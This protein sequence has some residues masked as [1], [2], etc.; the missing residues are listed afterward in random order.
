MDRL[1]HLR[2]LSYQRHANLQGTKALFALN[3]LVT[4]FYSTVSLTPASNNARSPIISV[5]G[6][7]GNGGRGRVFRGAF[8]DFWD[9]RT[10]SG[11]RNFPNCLWVVLLVL[12]F[13]Q[14]PRWA[15]AWADGG[16]TLIFTLCCLVLEHS[17]KGSHWMFGYV[18][19]V[20]LIRLMLYR[21]VWICFASSIA[22]L[23]AF[24]INI[25]EGESS[26]YSSYAFSIVQF[27]FFSIIFYGI[28]T[29]KVYRSL[30]NRLW[31][32][33][34]I[35]LILKEKAKRCH[36]SVTDMVSG[37][38]CPI[39]IEHI[40]PSKLRGC[41]KKPCG[42]KFN[43]ENDDDYNNVD[44]LLSGHTTP[45]VKSAIRGN[46]IFNSKEA[47]NETIHGLSS[48][49]LKMLKGVD[50]RFCALLAIRVCPRT[51][52]DMISEHE[53]F[54][55]TAIID[56][57][58]HK[59]KV[60]HV[61]NYGTTWVG[62]AGF[63]D[64]DNE[65]D[66][67]ISLL[68]NHSG[69]VGGAATSRLGSF[70]VSAQFLVWETLIM[71]FE[72]HAVM[73]HL[74]HRVVIAMEANKII[75]GFLGKTPS[76]DFFG[77][78]I[79]WVLRV[80]QEFPLYDEATTLL[81]AG[82]R[83]ILQAKG[84]GGGLKGDQPLEFV[85]RRFAPASS[86]HATFQ[87]MEQAYTLSVSGQTGAK[88]CAFISE[89]N[90][91]RYVSLHAEQGGDSQWIDGYKYLFS[92]YNA[93]LQSQTDDF[94]KAAVNNEEGEIK[95]ILTEWSYEV[96]SSEFLNH[97]DPKYR[98]IL[99][100]PILAQ[101]SDEQILD[102]HESALKDVQLLLRR[103][104]FSSFFHFYTL[105]K[106]EDWVGWNDWRPN[107]IDRLM[108][109]GLSSD[110]CEPA[111]PFEV[112][113]SLLAAIH[114]RLPEFFLSSSWRVSTSRKNPT[115][116]PA[117][118]TPLSG[119]N[120]NNNTWRKKVVPTNDSK[121]DA[122]MQNDENKIKS[123]ALTEEKSRDKMNFSDYRREVMLV[124]SS[125]FI[126]ACCYGVF[127]FS[128]IYCF[129]FFPT[130]PRGNQF[131]VVGRFEVYGFMWGVLLSKISIQR[132]F[133]GFAY[134]FQAW[135]IFFGSYKFPVSDAMCR[136]PN[137]LITPIG[138]MNGEAIAY[139]FTIMMFAADMRIPISTLF[140]FFCAGSLGLN[141]PNR[142]TI[143]CGDY[144]GNIRL[145]I[146]TYLAFVLAL[147]RWIMDYSVYLIYIVETELTPASLRL[148]QAD[149]V[150]ARNLL[151]LFEPALK[152]EHNES[153][154]LPRKYPNCTIITVNVKASAFLA[155]ILDC[156]EFETIYGQVSAIINKSITEFGLL[157]VTEFAGIVTVVECKDLSDRSLRAI[158]RETSR[159]AFFLKTLQQRVE[160][161]AVANKFN[162]E[163]DIGIDHGPAMVGLLG[164]RT[165]S[166]DLTGR[167][168]D[169][170]QIISSLSLAVS[171]K[172]QTIISGSFAANM[173]AMRHFSS[174][175]VMRPASLLYRASR[176]P[177]HL[178]E[179]AFSGMTLDD[180]DLI[181]MLGRGGYGSVHLVREV[182]TAQLYAVKVIPQ[183]ASFMASVLD[184]E[185]RALQRLNYPNVV[186]FKY[187][188]MN[189]SKVYLFMNYVEG[190][191]LQQ[192]VDK[193]EPPVV[194]LAFWF[195]ELTLAIEYVHSVGILHRDVKPANCMIGTDG[196]LRLC[197]FGL[198]KSIPKEN[199]S[200]D[201]IPLTRT[202]SYT[203]LEN[204]F[205]EKKAS[206]D[207]E[208]L[209]TLER[210]MPVKSR[211][212]ENF[213]EASYS[214]L[215]VPLNFSQTPVSAPSHK[216]LLDMFFSV[217]LSAS[218][219]DA[220]AL[221]A[222]HLKI[223]V[224]IIELVSFVAGGGVGDNAGTTAVDEMERDSRAELL[225]SLRACLREINAPGSAF[226]EIPVMVLSSPSFFEEKMQQ[227]LKREFLPLKHFLNAPLS[228]YDRATLMYFGRM[229][230]NALSDSEFMDKLAQHLQSSA[231]IPEPTE[232]LPTNLPANPG[233]KEPESHIVR[234]GTALFMAPEIILR[235]EYSKAIDW[236]ACGV[237]FYYCTT[238]NYLVN[239][240]TT[241][242]ALRKICKVDM[243]VSAL[244]P[245]SLPLEDLV[246]GL[247][248]RDVSERL[249]TRGAHQIR[250]HAFF[251]QLNWTT[252]QL[253]P[254]FKP[255]AELQMRVKNI[256]LFYGNTF[257]PKHPQGNPA[258][259]VEPGTNNGISRSP[260][261]ASLKMAKTIAKQHKQELAR[262]SS[263][264]SMRESWI[265]QSVE[266]SNASF[267]EQRSRRGGG[268]D[269]D[270]GSFG[271]SFFQQDSCMSIKE[272]VKEGSRGSGSGSG[273]LLSGASGKLGRNSNDA[274]IQNHILGFASS[275]FASP[276]NFL[277]R[278][279]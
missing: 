10:L 125:P 184:H 48:S 21:H 79:R 30:C 232:T 56:E 143:D 148:Y 24:R 129:N 199:I 152:H 94:L 163:L 7:Q 49:D 121:S 135:M 57:I 240:T 195:A 122:Q 55:L 239:G 154:V 158:Y 172:A 89:G 128:T 76:F 235:G 108:G 230:R 259:G 153:L 236:W 210:L 20:L 64:H 170:S 23:T 53:R 181:A 191:T 247:L 237:T 162:V 22:Y 1:L 268:A 109:R 146:I 100:D 243:D 132:T 175:F 251:K 74:K 241:A 270:T 244:R 155:G 229:A 17:G 231:V 200:R 31:D 127:F 189:D 207:P 160:D 77:P 5:Y 144:Q 29:E 275:D 136:A 102:W 218:F 66:E 124:S 273:K 14:N 11:M 271:I 141:L 249:G 180:F 59:R 233:R 43:D 250:T 221:L 88:N 267:K 185:F 164:G 147:L 67:D 166:L 65:I 90:L 201:S 265:R 115:T 32:H 25:P 18:S 93:L 120:L 266:G 42:D 178:V 262:F 208:T 174:H 216:A 145:Q 278:P 60:A 139:A 245:L 198:S 279:E 205:P 85:S 61:R 202:N 106:K 130:G 193:Y 15:G 58:A 78:E 111:A 118:T 91:R 274:A 269:G 234:A 33:M 167:T 190:G 220:K 63:F 159:T 213:K 194:H 253:V 186:S 203:L 70:S 255:D 222:N 95:K 242:D 254:P 8:F 134:A 34:H 138:D 137:M 156:K 131:Q 71:A 51:E 69:I 258:P 3:T 169:F 182:K 214:I 16:F 142:S 105:I 183:K 97:C 110:S 209:R 13:L 2:S 101:F 87:T 212:Q 225:E 276:P 41:K 35:L 238:R 104:F 37:H 246:R 133:D 257:R 176:L 46:L 116:N 196:H 82:V 28:L 54:A 219:D 227:S 112:L 117:P 211:L 150:D 260:E 261:R 126:T 252:F 206:L 12:P 197:D 4:L 192:V 277:H 19:C 75:G 36:V 27:S 114:I 83:S 264:Q 99:Q 263:L 103:H 204:A 272:E 168:R 217:T 84:R 98:A 38:L 39:V 26:K 81:S 107:T 228:F 188:L 68:E 9:I 165:H 45:L 6:E 140:I 256:P 149:L 179:Q 86:N 72:V 47:R 52:N 171:G 226:K 161:Y 151:L 73:K 224:V 123:A 44:T 187:S 62:C 92:E 40:F 119:R 113:R 248:N 50:K 173:R 215:L 177:I 223:D 157:K 96:V 80:T